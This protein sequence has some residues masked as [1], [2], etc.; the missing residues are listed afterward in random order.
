MTSHPDPASR[1]H[2]E[3]IAIEFLSRV[4]GPA[5]DLDAIDELMTEDYV[6]HSAGSSIR[7]R[8]AFKAWV[9]GFQTESAKRVAIRI[10]QT[11]SF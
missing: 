9:A 1:P 3:R 2:A 6:I 8:D 5:H 10:R 11:V 7:G 4:W